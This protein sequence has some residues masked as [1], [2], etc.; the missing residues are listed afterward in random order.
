MLLTVIPD[1]KSE[2]YP[3]ENALHIIQIWCPREKFTEFEPQMMLILNSIQI[4]EN[5]IPS[6]SATQEH[7]SCIPRFY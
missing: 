6:A 7:E 2:T 4:T 3:R 5:R 1:G